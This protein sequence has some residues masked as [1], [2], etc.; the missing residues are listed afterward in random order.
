M[1]LLTKYVPIELN[2]VCWRVINNSLDINSGSYL[3]G[4][5]FSTYSLSSFL[6]AQEI[7][8]SSPKLLFVN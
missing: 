1:C 7:C 6:E 5:F 4:N 2:G 3:F 8:E